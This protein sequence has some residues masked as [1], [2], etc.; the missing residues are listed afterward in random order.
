MLG[1][2]GAKNYKTTSRYSRP[3]PYLTMSE[4]SVHVHPSIHPPCTFANNRDGTPSGTPGRCFQQVPYFLI[5]I[6]APDFIQA[7]AWS[8]P[9]GSDRPKPWSHLQ[10]GSL[11]WKF[12][13]SKLDKTYL[14][15][16]WTYLF[17]TFT[18]FKQSWSIL[19]LEI[20]V[21]SVWILPFPWPATSHWGLQWCVLQSRPW[22]G[23]QLERPWVRA[24]LYPW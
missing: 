16:I 4:G 24:A 5:H 14:W 11:W 17:P 21:D 19:V 3:E 20:S 8:R 6:K 1:Y 2:L 7:N 18:V 9:T 13:S 15:I 22:Q 23:P 10:K 12:M